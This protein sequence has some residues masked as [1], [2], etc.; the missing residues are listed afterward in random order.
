MPSV[1]VLPP[2]DLLVV[3]GGI[4][5]AGIARDAAGRGLR[6][7]LCEQDDLAQH[8]SSAS[9]K[10]IHGGLRYLEHREFGLVRKALQERE[11]LLR[12]A[13]HIIRPL[14]F[15]VPHDAAQRPAWL[16]R[17]GL[18]L[19]DHLARRRLLPASGAIRLAGHPAGA[20]LKPGFRRAFVYSDGW[21]DDARLVVL[22]ALDAFEHGARIMTRTRCCDLERG[23]DGWLATLQLA[24]GGQ[25][26]LHARVLVNATG[27]WAAGFARLAAAPSV[28]GPRLAAAP[29]V[30]GSRLAA[31]PSAI[32]LRLATTA[33]E[34]GGLRLVKG[35]HIVVRRLFDH[36][37]AYLFQNPDG[38]IV[39]AMPFQR[40][41]TLIGT[42]DVDYDGDPAL[43]AIDGDEERYLCEMASRYFARPVTPDDIVWRFSGVR[44]LLDDGE[45]A[46]ALSRDYRLAY[47][48][49]PGRAPLL[50]VWGGKIT[51]YRRLA[52][53][54]LAML[55]PR[56]DNAGPAW[57]A[58][59]PLPGGD[60]GLPAVLADVPD[61][62]AFLECFRQR[63]RWLPDALSER[64]CRLYGSRADR[65]IGAARSMAALGRELV[66]GLYEAEARYLVEHEWAA[67]A[68]DILWRRTKLGL[69]CLR[70]DAE[71]LDAW[72]RARRQQPAAEVQRG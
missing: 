72:L 39:F 53:E 16:I 52:E 51:T 67:S 70:G 58:T 25:A 45:A 20:V 7:V 1:P 8:T 27:P 5:G 14:R 54:A 46:A 57:T 55:L 10:L 11:L 33:P 56:F 31:T 61:F 40:D 50:N 59:R 18:F 2:C 15:V 47:D 64:Y 48:A 24:G 38:R 41:F 49:G 19:Y 62:E 43:V 68:D 4:N 26:R 17:A 9:T 21:V 12:L 6:V 3:G 63:H 30:A 28:V 37:Y 44:A 34:A 71:R 60:L 13:P 32:G 35:S 42:T 65:M 69:H 36:P 22:N 66:P 23:P 29:L